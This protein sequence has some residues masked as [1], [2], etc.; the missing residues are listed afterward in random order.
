VRTD[1]TQTEMANILDVTFQQYQK[2]EKGN[3]RIYAEQLLEICSKSKWN[4]ETF[5]TDPNAILEIYENG[6]EDGYQLDQMKPEKIGFIKRKFKVLDDLYNNH[7]N[8]REQC[9]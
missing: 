7:L 4:V 5:V 3:N 9:T 1:K 2:W 8:E 6:H